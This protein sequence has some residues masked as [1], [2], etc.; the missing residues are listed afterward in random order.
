MLTSHRDHTSVQSH[1]HVGVQLAHVLALVDRHHADQGQ[2]EAAAGGRGRALAPGF[3]AG[4]VVMTAFILKHPREPFD[5]HLGGT[6]GLARQRHVVAAP[7]AQHLRHRPQ[8]HSAPHWNRE[9]Q[10]GLKPGP[11]LSEVQS[12][13]GHV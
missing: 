1:S 6:G 4:V 7:R 10:Q 8:L 5:V 2:S 12:I 3:G 13:L 9:G 11:R